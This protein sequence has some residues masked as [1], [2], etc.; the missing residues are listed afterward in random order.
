M[1][2]LFT[3]IGKSIR[4]TNTWFTS[5]ERQ[6]RLIP[7]KYQAFGLALNALSHLSNPWAAD[8]LSNIWFTVFKTKPKPWITRFWQQADS[9]VELHLKDKSI[10]VSLWGRGPLV[11]LM[12]GWSGSGVQFRRLIRGLVSAGYQVAA[13]DAPAH[14]SNPGKQSHLLEFIDSLLAIQQQIGT[15][16]TVIAHSLG[17]MAAVAAAQR[18]LSVR[19]L[20]LFAP[21]LDVQE[22]YQ[23]YADLLNLNPVL[24]NKFRDTIGQKMADIFGVADIWNLLTPANMLA[25]IKCQGLM[26]YDNAD[27]EIPQHQFKSIAHYWPGC[28]VMETKGLG[29]NLILKDKTVIQNVLD[30]MRKTVAI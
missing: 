9:C 20:V 19:Q 24:S 5:S 17:G 29:H 25:Q 23:T 27:E 7:F 6:K 16:D 10:P 4:S 28:Q 18:G 12:H 2:Q 14:G 30:F 21:H 3:N 26:I 11:V 13:F 8:I 22:M 15:V 1:S